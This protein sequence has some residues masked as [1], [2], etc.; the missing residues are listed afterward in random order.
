MN[1]IK[2]FNVKAIYDGEKDESYLFEKQSNKRIWK[3]DGYDCLRD[4]WLK[5]NKEVEKD[6]HLS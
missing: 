2:R 1:Y 6:A 3:S 5:Y 4:M